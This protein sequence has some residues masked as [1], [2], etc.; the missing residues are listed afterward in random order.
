MSIIKEIEMVLKIFGGY[1]KI[2]M[3]WEV[4]N[5]INKCSDIGMAIFEY[6]DCEDQ[7]KKYI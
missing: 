5:V 2:V 7:L 6:D 3:G 1:S 4:C